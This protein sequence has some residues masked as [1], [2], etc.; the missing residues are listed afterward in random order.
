M[1]WFPSYKITGGLLAGKKT[2]AGGSLQGLYDF[3]SASRQASG[4]IRFAQRSDFAN[5]NWDGAF[6]TSMLE[7]LLNHAKTAYAD[8]NLGQ[9]YQLAVIEVENP[10]GA[11][12]YKQAYVIEVMDDPGCSERSNIVSYGGLTYMCKWFSALWSFRVSRFEWATP[13][14][15][16]TRT[17]LTANSS[18]S[19]G[20]ACEILEESITGSA[21]YAF[22][23]G[24]LWDKIYLSLG[25]FTDTNNADCFGVSIFGWRY[26][27]P[28]Y[29]QPHPSPDNRRSFGLIGA[30]DT[31]LDQLF[32]EFKLD[33]TEDPNDDPNNPKDEED[34]G[35]GGHDRPVDPIPVPDL[36]PVGA[37][38]A[39][40]V[41][42]YRLTPAQMEDFAQNFFTD[43][44]LEYIRD[45]L[46][47]PMDAIIGVSLLPYKPSGSD[48]WY[49]MIGNTYLTMTPLTK[50]STQ[51]N[52]FDF[53]A[54]HIDE[55]GAN[56]YDYSPYTKIL[57]WLPYIGY[58]ELPVDEVMGKT[59]RVMYHCDCLSGDCVAFILSQV[60]PQG[61]A[62]LPV[63]VVIAQFN[64]NVLSQ[65]PHGSDT[66]GTLM[67]SV[68]Q[69]S[70][71]GIGVL[72]NSAIGGFDGS[73]LGQM[74]NTLTSSVAGVVNSMKS[75]VKR[76]GT[77]GGSAGMMGIQYPYIIRL[78]PNQSLPSNYAK[79]M[80]YPSNI[81]GPLSNGFSGLAV[82]EDIQL[83]NIPALEPERIEIMELLRKGVII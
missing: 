67:Q 5:D 22:T 34:G 75:T 74:A 27:I 55:Y 11:Q 47:D 32:G 19:V 14:A 12:Y 15:A 31:Y 44:I 39:G 79:I 1:P 69:A 21:Y 18:R 52:Q 36:P 50:I 43:T 23:G 30:L 25:P 78:I 26:I 10:E 80:G 46:A 29:R 6:G 57:I 49:P 37:A 20:S 9:W 60:K 2:P 58:R 59:I 83:N 71:S 56:V 38:D 40:F 64:G 76:D 61:V 41:T 35:D 45:M 42:M 24:W 8:G 13:T 51:Y 28:T 48:S 7:E 63:D 77:A 3:P 53:G 82:V 33:E 66:F 54:I 4:N 62:S 68:V 81:S 73:S 65:V 70:C 17:D 16:Y 72:A